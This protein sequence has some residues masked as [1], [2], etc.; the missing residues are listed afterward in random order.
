[1][2]P[3]KWID[4]KTAETYTL[5]HRSQED[6]LY[7]DPDAPDRVLLKVEN[8]NSARSK[9]ERKDKWSGRPSGGK[10]K[11]AADLEAEAEEFKKQGRRENEGE[12]A[13]YGITYD[14]SKYDYMQ[15]LKPIGDDP[16]AIF[17]SRKDL[18]K[19]KGR[20]KGGL[21]FK[22]QAANS[23]LPKEVLP[24]EET[25]TR[26]YQDQQD[27]PDELAGLQ[28]DMDPNLREVLEALD[29]EAFIEEG[30]EGEEE[31]IFADL[32]KSG[33]SDKKASE[34][35]DFD[36]DQYDDEDFGFDSDDSADTV[37]AS[38]KANVP[39][40]EPKEGEEEWETAFRQFKLEQSRRKDDSDDDL[41]SEDP[42]EKRTTITSMTRTT[43]NGSSRR[44][45][46]KRGART[47]L[48]GLSMSSSALFRND[49]LSLL[50]DRFDKIEE[51][52]EDTIPEEPEGD[53]NMAEERQ[54]FE[55]ALDDF[56]DNYAIEGKKLVKHKK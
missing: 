39:V 23:V 18:D 34:W 17:I 13:L 6:P 47:E 35:D 16:S 24:S 1:M 44:R 20:H 7:N 33:V 29:D 48:T 3:K 15:H 5:V 53:F 43:Q 56:L 40:V 51:E 45:A 38:S 21:M 4:K 31:D 9:A 10:V 55:A 14:D 54:D 26:T 19:S 8:L 22:S 46:R 2:P 25:V 11:T 49:G 30:E 32:V 36:P 52:Y 50:D 37:K 28:P 41:A 27:L 12:A 42:D